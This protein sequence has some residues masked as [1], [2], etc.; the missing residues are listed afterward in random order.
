[1]KEK[2]IHLINIT[3]CP[4]RGGHCSRNTGENVNLTALFELSLQGT[5]K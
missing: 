3:E 4:S 5:K 1:M 2:S